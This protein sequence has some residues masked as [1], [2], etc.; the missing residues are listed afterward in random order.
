MTSTD[1]TLITVQKSVV[2]LYEYTVAKVTMM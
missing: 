2:F 1:E